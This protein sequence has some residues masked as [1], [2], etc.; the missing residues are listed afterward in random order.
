MAG[1]IAIPC[2][3]I[4]CSYAA[5]N[6]KSGDGKEVLASVKK[7]LDKAVRRATFLGVWKSQ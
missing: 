1:H 5:K 3:L 2:V 7:Y 6:A 4:V